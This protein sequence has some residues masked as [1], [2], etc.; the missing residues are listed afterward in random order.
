MTRTLRRALAA[1]PLAAALLAALPA[2]ASAA[3]TLTVTAGSYDY[4]SGAGVA[5]RLSVSETTANPFITFTET[6]ETITVAGPNAATCAGSGTMNVTCATVPTAVDVN[7]GDLDDKLAYNAFSV[8]SHSVTVDTGTGNDS[9]LNVGSSLVQFT[10]N[11]ATEPP[12]T[13]NGNDGDDNL[14][15]NA[16][17]NIGQGTATIVNGGNGNDLLKN[18]NGATLNGDANNDTF[19]PSN[20]GGGSEFSE[21]MNGGAGEDIADYSGFTTGVNVSVDAVAN[22][23]PTTGQTDNVGADSSVENVRGSGGADTITGTL[24]NQ[25]NKFFGGSANDT[26]DGGPGDDVLDGEQGADTMNGGANGA[27]GD[28]VSYAARS[29]SVTADNDGVADDGENGL[30]VPTNPG[31]PPASP[32]N[33]GDNVGATVENITGGSGNDSLTGDGA[34][35]ALTGNGGDDTLDGNAGADTLGG[36]AGDD[37]LDG[38]A[39]GDTINGDSGDDTA[40]GGAGTDTV[41][42]GNGFDRLDGGAG[43]DTVNGDAGGDTI[44][45]M[46]G[47]ADTVNCGTGTDNVLPDASGDTVNADCEISGSGGSGGL[48]PA[49]P[50]GPAGPQGSKGEQ[51]SPGSKGDQGPAGAQGMA[52]PQ[53]PQGN[54]G[55]DVSVGCQ[56]EPNSAKTRLAVVCD[57]F[58]TGSSRPIVA[59][60]TR[61]SKTFGR[62]SSKIRNNT[63]RFNLRTSKLS[64]GRYRLTLT[65]KGVRLITLGVTIR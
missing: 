65:Q 17:N 5:N 27:T 24:A 21:T 54:P 7:L 1:I 30:V 56:V 34:A 35:N 22:D 47:A 19:V 51:G 39:D 32:Q 26:I 48:G 9:E 55:Q 14:F 60:L 58:R 42:G 33:E 4:D 64:K 59:K 45:A 31:Q 63:V 46:D 41:N 29:G 37:D 2:M 43:T 8:A 16:G 12:I 52:G 6:T 57:V 11:S 38:A 40:D 36:G 13:V 18:A 53:G 25:N 50:A 3:A 61:G 23:G 10:T 15:V 62:G 49:G 44:G 28:T 20:P